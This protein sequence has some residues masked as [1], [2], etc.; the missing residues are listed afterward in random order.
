MGPGVER[1]GVTFIYYPNLAGDEAT[2]H[3]DLEEFDPS[4][5][6]MKGSFSL[7]GLEKQCS[8]L[9]LWF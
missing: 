7:L 9:T 6:D 1:S 8:M 2:L 5:G 3:P 4:M